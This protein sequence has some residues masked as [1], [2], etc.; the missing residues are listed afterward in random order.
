MSNVSELLA[1]LRS[2]NAN[3][4][5]EACE[6][7]RV[8]P[9][10]PEEA[11]A[12]LRAVIND[13]DPLVE[14]AATRALDVHAKHP[15]LSLPSPPFPP[16]ARADLALALFGLA[17]TVLAASIFV[18]SVCLATTDRAPYECAEDVGVYLVAPFDPPCMLRLFT[19]APSFDPPRKVSLFP[20]IGP[21]YFV[22]SFCALKYRDIKPRRSRIVV[23]AVVACVSGI[24]YDLAAVL[25]SLICN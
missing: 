13:P 17:V 25:T 14:Y 6:G 15:R 1:M 16:I 18:A 20:L 7:L 19:V 22:A 10:I 3:E 4:R 23:V 11:K 21:L 5:Y 8:T 12:A 9:R 24:L 2:P